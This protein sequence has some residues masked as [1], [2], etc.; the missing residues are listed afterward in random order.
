MEPAD[1]I[2]NLINCLTNDEDYRQ[3]LW[4]HYLSGNSEDTLSS[5]LDFLVNSEDRKFQER[6]WH[7]YK[8]PPSEK[9]YKLLS[10]FSAIEQSIMCL[11]MLGLS[12]SELSQY[13]GI[14]EVRIRQVIQVIRYNEAW[15]EYK[16]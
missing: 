3:E 10:R 8:N 4:L 11:L 12:I 9:F 14:S 7:L 15:D 13:K 6:L 5:H 1:R 16:E 2:S